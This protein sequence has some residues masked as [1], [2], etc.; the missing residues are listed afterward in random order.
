MHCAAH[1]TGAKHSSARTP[2][3]IQH[4]AEQ[5]GVFGAGGFGYGGQT[6]STVVQLGHGSPFGQNSG[7]WGG[8]TSRLQ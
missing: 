2:S 3:R 7:G 5:A 1:A 8:L 4:A 6:H